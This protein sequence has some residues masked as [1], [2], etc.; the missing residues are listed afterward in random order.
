MLFKPVALLLADLSVTKTTARR[1]EAL[2][3]ARVRKALGDPTF[4]DTKR[5]GASDPKGWRLIRIQRA[6][7]PRLD[8]P[9]QS[10]S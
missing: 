8:V 5:G 2:K 9:S 6:L 7:Q 4:A 1:I 10:H 3:P